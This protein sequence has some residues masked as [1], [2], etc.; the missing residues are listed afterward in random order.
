MKQHAHKFAAGNFV[1]ALDN[2]SVKAK[3]MVSTKPQETACRTGGQLATRVREALM[4][5]AAKARGGEK[6]A[7]VGN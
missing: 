5:A 6:E 3:Q 7:G 1:V 4:R 2:N